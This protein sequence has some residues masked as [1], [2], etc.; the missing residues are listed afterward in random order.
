MTTSPVRR[1]DPQELLR[2]TPFAAT[3]GIEFDRLDPEEVTARLP[4]AP[5][6]CTVGGA[7]H[8]GALVTL[9]DAAAGVCAFL[10]LPAGSTG[11][12]TIELKTNFLHAV[13]AGV[14]TATARPLHL[15]R[16]VAVIQTDLFDDTATR[17]A[18]VTQT[19]AILR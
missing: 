15:G 10:N 9:G 11:T 3:V 16:T 17:V 5:E 8:G 13:R 18:Q 7:L 1:L 12:T 4:W 14:V 2:L 19:Q 6:R